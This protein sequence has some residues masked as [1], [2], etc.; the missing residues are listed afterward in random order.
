MT[1]KGLLCLALALS[2]ILG[3]SSCDKNSGSSSAYDS[4]SL[5]SDSLMTDSSSVQDSSRAAAETAI[6]DLDE[7]IAFAE[8]IFSQEAHLADESISALTNSSPKIYAPDD[9]LQVL[10]YKGDVKLFGESFG[11]AEL[12]EGERGGDITSLSFCAN[13]RAD[14]GY[15]PQLSSEECEYI[16]T[17][18][19]GKLSAL[20]GEPQKYDDGLF[21]GA[22]FTDTHIKNTKR[23][24]IK[25]CDKHSGA[26]SFVNTVLCFEK[27]QG[28]KQ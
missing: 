4:S 12:E 26:G 18:L 25:Y 11:A 17:S 1:A 9:G 27:R 5:Q 7:G 19:L 28:L 24:I 15:E 21:K 8:K 6:A 3:L 20:Y 10:C 14:I 22:Y 23:V 2:A 13:A 16:Y